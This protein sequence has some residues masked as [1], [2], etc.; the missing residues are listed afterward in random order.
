M[1]YRVRFSFEESLTCV[2]NMDDFAFKLMDEI[3]RHRLNIMSF[4]ND[5]TPARRNGLVK[6]PELPM[7]HANGPTRKSNSKYAKLSGNAKD[8][9]DLL[10]TEFTLPNHVKKKANK[11]SALAETLS[12]LMSVLI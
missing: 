5:L 6:R 11:S 9:A 7:A 3:V 12:C 10:I 8:P 4:L 1:N 2:P